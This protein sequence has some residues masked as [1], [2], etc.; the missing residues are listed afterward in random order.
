MSVVKIQTEKKQ[1]ICENIKE[2]TSCLV[3]LNSTFNKRKIRF[4]T[5]TT[6]TLVPTSVLVLHS[7]ET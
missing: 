6:Q 1:I 4:I 7:D 3:A 2:M 5:T